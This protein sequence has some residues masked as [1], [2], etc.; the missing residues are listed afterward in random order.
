M[1]AEP[2][3][4]NEVAS[5]PSME[6]DLVSAEPALENGSACCYITSKPREYKGWSDADRRVV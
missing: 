6:N 1:S 4:E 3:L 5:E 2:S